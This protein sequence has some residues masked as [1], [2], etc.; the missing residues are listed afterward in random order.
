MMKTQRGF[1]LVELMIVV[2]VIGVLA[3]IAYPSYTDYLTRGRIPDA[4]S[5]LSNKR[6]QVEQFYQD[7][8]TYTGAPACVA[9]STTSQYFDFSCSVLTANAYTLQAVGKGAMVGFTYTIDQS[10]AKTSTITASGW[11]GNVG[12]WVTKKGGAC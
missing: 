3:S 10:N 12:C 5:N 9:D 11:T 4:T 2:V 7:N 1:T 8:R 6:V